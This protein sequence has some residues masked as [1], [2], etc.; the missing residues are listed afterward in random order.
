MVKGG[1]GR[2]RRG[3]PAARGRK[4]YVVMILMLAVFAIGI[5]LLAAVP[6]W[7]TEV[8]REQEEELIFR[9]NQ[10][11][12]AVRL[13]TAK[14]PGRFPTSLKELL[15]KKF[16]RKLYKDPLTE[17]GEWTVICNPSTSGSSSSSSAGGSTGQEILLVPEKSLS[18]VRQPV[19]LGVAGSSPK[20]SIRIYNGQETYDRW[21]FFYGQDPEKFPKITRY[22]EKSK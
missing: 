16:I 2:P 14:N 10:Y 7:Q 6:L 1:T 12:E 17:S 9:G 13:Y 4:G 15:E 18:S 5:G 8:R 21:L 19:I 20:Q 11:V 22:G 3:A